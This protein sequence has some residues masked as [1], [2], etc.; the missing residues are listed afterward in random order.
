[1]LDFI[2]WNANPDIISGPLTVRWYGLMFAV[3]FLLGYNILGRIFRHEGAPEKWLGILLFWVVGATIIGSRLGHVFFYE[4]SY[5]SA[6]PLDIIKVWAVC[7]RSVNAVFLS[8]NTMVKPGSGG[9]AVLEH[10]LELRQNHVPISTTCG[11][12]LD[13]FPAGQIEHFTQGIVASEAGLVFG[14]LAELAVET[15]NDI[16]RVYEKLYQ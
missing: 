8:G 9:L 12:V 11:P 1:M 4:W 16:G 13:N 5:Y 6:H 15:P 3:G 2:V 10:E 7:A 14:D